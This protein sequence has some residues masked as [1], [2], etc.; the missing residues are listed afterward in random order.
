LFCVNQAQ[1]NIT[2]DTGKKNTLKKMND[3]WKQYKSTLVTEWMN[4]GKNPVGH[5]EGLT[6]EIWDDFVA[7]KQTPEFQ[8]TKIIK[9]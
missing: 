5:F 3:G 4:K 9:L 1:W 8:V 6:Q 2:D 7:I